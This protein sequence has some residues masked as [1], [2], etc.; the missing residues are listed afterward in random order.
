MQTE[1]WGSLGKS[2]EYIWGRM[3]LLPLVGF[4]KTES[5]SGGNYPKG[6]K[7]EEEAGVRL[8]G[9]IHD[10]LHASPGLQTDLALV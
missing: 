3:C 10:S 9:G 2:G 7:G 8:W 5:P 4:L 6:E 1:I